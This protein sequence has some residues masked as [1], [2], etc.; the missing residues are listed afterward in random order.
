MK[1]FEIRNTF[2]HLADMSYDIGMLPF[3]NFKSF[4]YKIIQTDKIE[5]NHELNFLGNLT[6][7][8]NSD[9]PICDQSMPIISSKM[10]N[11]LTQFGGLEI[12]K[13]RINII[14]DSFLGEK[15]DLNGNIKNEVPCIVDFQ[16]V[17]P[18]LKISLLDYDKSDYDPMTEWEQFPTV[19]RKFVVK[20]P[21][22]ELPPIFRVTERPSSLFITEKVKNKL[23]E[24]EIRGIQFEEL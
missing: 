8:E 2:D 19:I 22:Q 15:F 7:I 21:E 18:K 11:I 3:D 10:L 14:D 16:I 6:A 23:E 24:N 1:I 9:Y 13:Y 17:Q 12:N 20:T 4:R 5:L